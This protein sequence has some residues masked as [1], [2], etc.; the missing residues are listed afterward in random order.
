MTWK[1]TGMHCS[2]C[3]ILIDENVEDLEGVT[4]SNTS[5]KKKVTTVTFD[6]SRCNPAQIAAAIIGAGYQA[7]P[8]TDAPRTARR[9]WLRR[10]TG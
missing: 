7:A 5:M 1:V 4:S 10:A 3:S 8:A 6:I 9:S 2:S